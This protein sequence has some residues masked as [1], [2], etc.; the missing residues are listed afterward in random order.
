VRC[1]ER[2]LIVDPDRVEPPAEPP[3]TNPVA[4]AA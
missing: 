2:G 3:A 4:S 1:E